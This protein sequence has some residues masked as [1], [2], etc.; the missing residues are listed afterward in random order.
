M[1]NLWAYGSLNCADLLD[2]ESNYYL[3][4]SE[5]ESELHYTI[6]NIQTVAPSSEL[7]CMHITFGLE[8][9]H[10]MEQFGILH[11]Q[12]CAHRNGEVIFNEFQFLSFF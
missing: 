5:W 4:T 9:R 2:S 10:I 11:G 1:I 6:Y 3:H 7:A 12:H 8:H